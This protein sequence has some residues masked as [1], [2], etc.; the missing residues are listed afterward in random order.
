V[1]GSEPPGRR[2][3]RLRRPSERATWEAVA[4]L[5]VL[6]VI[7]AVAAEGVGLISH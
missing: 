7:L 5:I 1:I 4:I 6:A 3:W 2:A